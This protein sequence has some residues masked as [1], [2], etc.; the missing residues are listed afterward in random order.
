MGPDLSLA[1]L[2]PRL[3]LSLHLPPLVLRQVQ[4]GRGWDAIRDPIRWLPVDVT[5]V[6]CRCFPACASEW[7]PCDWHDRLDCQPLPVVR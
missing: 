6:D 7:G 2:L 5:R 1:P 4:E 3:R